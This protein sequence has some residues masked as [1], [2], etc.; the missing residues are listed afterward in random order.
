MVNSNKH[1]VGIVHKF[2][3]ASYM[4]ILLM[5]FA[6]FTAVHVAVTSY[7]EYSQAIHRALLLNIHK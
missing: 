6:F 2:S 3:I 5:Q 1:R 4:P 7:I